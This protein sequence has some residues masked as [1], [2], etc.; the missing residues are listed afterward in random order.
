MEICADPDKCFFAEY[1]T[2]TDLRLAYRS[3]MMP[4]MWLVTQLYNLCEYC[5]A[6]D[7]LT[8]SQYREMAFVLSTNWPYLK[9]SEYMLFFHRFKSGRY[10]RFYGSIDPLIITQ[11]L[12]QFCDERAKAIDRHEQEEREKRM[13]E[14]RK[15]S[16]TWE[17]YCEQTGQQG[18]PSPLTMLGQ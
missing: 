2:L 18:K 7:K 15:R 10:G 13:D 8:D 1:P 3:E 14:S 17:Q 12:R 4:Q 5:G 11:A 6:R 16:I 9:V